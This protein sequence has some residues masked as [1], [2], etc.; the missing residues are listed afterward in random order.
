MVF[1]LNMCGKCLYHALDILGYYREMAEQ[2]GISLLA[3]AGIKEKWEESEIIGL[4]QSG[5]LFFPVKIMKKEELFGDL[6]ITE[7][8][9]IDTPVFF[10]LDKDFRVLDVFKPGY[11]KTE[12]LYRWLSLI[13]D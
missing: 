6:K 12:E 10:Y 13:L 2:K 7:P 1:D 3:I 4:H 5:A 9:L 11:L 8:D